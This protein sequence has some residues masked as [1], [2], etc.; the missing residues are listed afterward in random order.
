MIDHIGETGHETG[1]VRGI[2]IQRGTDRESGPQI[3]DEDEA[4]NGT[5]VI[6]EMIPEIGIGDAARI[7]LTHTRDIEVMT[8]EIGREEA[9]VPKPAM[10]VTLII[11][12]INV[13]LILWKRAPNPRQLRCRLM[14]KRK[15]S[16]LPN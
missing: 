16:V 1:D 11:F 12:P 10:S 9:E 3:E 5:F 4:V 6:G 8:I 13:A 14:K 15:R 2:D 7:L